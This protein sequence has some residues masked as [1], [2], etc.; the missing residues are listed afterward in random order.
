MNKLRGFTLIVSVAI[1]AT[2]LLLVALSSSRFL[3]QQLSSSVGLED[4][5][6]AKYLAEGCA[7][8]ALASLAAD[9]AVYVGNETLTIGGQSCIIETITTVGSV[10]T[11]D[12]EATVSTRVYRV[13]VLLSSLDPMT[14][15]SWQRVTSF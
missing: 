2:V 15:S 7:E 12:T 4:H 11:I 10:T 1:V 8:A 13:E 9:P 5:L 3:I 14:I 6:M